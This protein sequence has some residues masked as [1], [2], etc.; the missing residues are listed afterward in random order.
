MFTN[1]ATVIFRNITICTDK[2]SVTKQ[3]EEL[4]SLKTYSNKVFSNIGDRF[5]NVAPGID[6]KWEFKRNIKL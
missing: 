6:E 1:I 3:M 4:F 5:K 2:K